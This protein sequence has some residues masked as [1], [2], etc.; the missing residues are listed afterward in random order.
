[1]TTRRIAACAIAVVA[2]T[3]PAMAAQSAS[4]APASRCGT[5]SPWAVHAS[6]VNLRSGPG[7]K[8]VAV[9]VLY[10]SQKFTVHS[11]SGNWVNVTDNST[12]VRGWASMDY[13]YNTA[14]MCLD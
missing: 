3:L 13:V 12:G 14:G 2:L 11:T 8:Y 10:P 7:T 1:M 6:A 5:G 4:A 9:G